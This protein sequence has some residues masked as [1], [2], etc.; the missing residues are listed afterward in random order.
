MSHKD[1]QRRGKEMIDLIADYRDTIIKRRVVPDVKPGY[2]RS[3][4]PTEAPKKPEDWDAILCD[5]DQKILPGLAHWLHPR[6]H[7]YFPSGGS[8]ASL[9]GDMVSGM[10]GCVAF[11]WNACPSYTELEIVA[12]DWLA[13]AM[14]L[15]EFFLHECGAGGGGAFQMS[16]SSSI[17]L[18][19]LTARRMMTLKLREEDPENDPKNPKDLSCYLPRLVAYFSSIAHSALPKAAD[20]TVVQ[21]RALETDDNFSMRGDTLEKAFIAKPTTR[22]SYLLAWTPNSPDLTPPDFFIWGFVKDIVYSQKPTNIDDLRVKITQA[23]QQITLLMLQRTWAELHHRY[24]LCRQMKEDIAEG[25]VPFYVSATLGTTD[26][27]SFDNLPELAEV[28]RKHPDVWLHVDAA[29]AGSAMICPEFKYL[30]EGME[31]IDSFNV[32]PYKWLHTHHDAAAYYV[33]DAWKLNE[34]MSADPLYLHDTTEKV[35]VTF[36][37][38]S[39]PLSRRLRGCK[40]WFVF[41]DFGIEGLQAY[42][43]N[44][45]CMAKY[46]EELVRKDDRFEVVH[47]VTMGLVCVRLCGSNEQNKDLLRTINR[48]G[49][50][51]LSPTEVKGKYIIRICI[52]CPETTKEHVG[53]LASHLFSSSKPVMGKVLPTE[54][55]VTRCPDFAGHC[56]RSNGFI[57]KRLAL[58]NNNN[59]LARKDSQVQYEA[60]ENM[61]LGRPTEEQTDMKCRNKD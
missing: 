57:V 26:V 35:T 39:I 52:V 13:K 60:E 51:H 59:K 25:L 44:H 56:K 48:S 14:G 1:F 49:E 23:F 20:L 28:C 9:L 18:S 40:L 54:T 53:K 32:N 42:I 29:Y 19:M 4:L 47:E 24:E 31:H 7:A 33:K 41:R 37:N 11:S 45:C 15:P 21:Y 6:F 27:C 8:Y 36:R 61:S 34:T 43:R 58:E 3:L 38:W 17:Y 16:A 2:L 22:S 12:L 46:L 10:G 30:L 5:V 50:L 55:R